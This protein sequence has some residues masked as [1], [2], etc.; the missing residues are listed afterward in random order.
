VKEFLDASGTGSVS[1]RDLETVSGLSRF[2]LTRQFKSVFAT[3]PHRY[4][5]MRRL[6]RGRQL[7]ARGYSIADTAAMT[8]FSD[9]S[10]FHRHFLKAFGLTPGRWRKLVHGDT[11]DKGG[12]D[13]RATLAFSPQS[14]TNPA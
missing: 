14:K 3:S 1:S 13:W 5:V 4:L 11:A 6:G 10:H 12:R 9:Q 7:L 2:T 8:G